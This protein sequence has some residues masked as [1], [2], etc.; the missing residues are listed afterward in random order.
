MDIRPLDPSDRQTA[1][2][3]L[4]LQRASYRIEARL[5]GFDRLPPLVETLAELQTSDETFV[6]AFVDG[7]MVGVASWR[8]DGDTLDIHRLAVHPQALR[9]GLGRAL[10]RAAL[11]AAPSGGRVVVQTGAANDPARALY[12]AEGFHLVGERDVLPGLRVAA[13]ERA[14]P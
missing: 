1:A 5:I 9:Q 12:V 7:A 3:V 4:A 13:F 10:V 11:A 8:L 2:G 6:G 14:V